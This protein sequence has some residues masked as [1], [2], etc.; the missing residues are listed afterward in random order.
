M[1]NSLLAALLLLPSLL[2]A[3][4][5]VTV[6]G[7]I[8]NEKGDGIEYVQI[9]MPSHQIGTISTADGRFEIEVPCDTLY[10]FHVSYQP[11]AYPVTGPADDVVIV[12]HEQELPPAVFIGGNTKEKYLLKPGTGL[13][14]GMG[15]ITTS[16]RSEHPSGREIGS[17]A[18]T[19]KPFL[20]RDILLTVRSNHIPGCVA[21]INI[22]RIE[23]KRESFVNVLHKPIYFDVAVSDNPQEFDLQPE[24]TLLL[25]PGIY[26]I[27]FQIVGCD[28][29]ALRAFLTKS[30]DEREFWEMSM[31]FNIYL[32]S[33]YV[34]EVALGEIEHLPVNIGVAVKGLEFQ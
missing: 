2:F 14:K 29:E 18:L 26:F 8:V 23:G 5:H 19:K 30:E 24:E 21:S 13:M 15:I 34:R 31:D 7:R 33:S 9:G 12:L 16:L 10:F 28:N 25:E 1:R 3:Q 32:K 11:A 17:V 27:A 20:V 22:Y 4:E 6:K